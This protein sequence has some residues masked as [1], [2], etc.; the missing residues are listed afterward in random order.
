MLKSEV[1]KAISKETQLPKK[2][3]EKILNNA[4]DIASSELKSG[5]ELSLVRFGVLDLYTRAPRIA[6]VPGQKEHVK[7]PAK[8]I[9]RFTP[10][11]L[12]MEKINN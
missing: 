2:T 5:N 6:I 3:I 11:K 12:L 8:K 1:I 10:S 9:V 4:V 7:V